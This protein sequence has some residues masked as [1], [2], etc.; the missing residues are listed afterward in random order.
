MPYPHVRDFVSY[1][2]TR[3]SFKILQYDM[4]FLSPITDNERRFAVTSMSSIKLT[5]PTGAGTLK[6]YKDDLAK[7][8]AATAKK[9]QNEGTSKAP[10]HIYTSSPERS[11]LKK[12]QRRDSTVD[13]GKKVESSSKTQSID[14]EPDSLMVLLS[15]GISSFK[16]LDDFLKKSDEFLLA[17]DE[18][19][20]KA[21]KTDDVFYT[22]I[23]S[24][25]QV[26]VIC[27]WFLF[28]LLDTLFIQY[29]L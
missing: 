3:R 4:K 24:T 6:R 20:L 22:S 10:E 8:R 29:L 19:F 26:I 27:F 12:Q 7:K 25:F 16:E 5:L 11:P 9:Q 28:C 18:I 1:V 13:C 2:L 23:L 14:L 15:S 17:A 21:K